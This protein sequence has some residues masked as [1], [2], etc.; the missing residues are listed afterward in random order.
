MAVQAQL[1]LSQSSLN[2]DSGQYLDYGEMSV[3]N[4][5]ADPVELAIG[6]DVRCYDEMDAMALQV[7]I[8]EVCFDFVNIDTLL[9]VVNI[10]PVL[11]LAGGET[12]DLISLHQFFAD[13]YGSEWVLTFFDRENPEDNVELE[14]FVGVCDQANSIEQIAVQTVE[15]GRAYP[16]PANTRVTIPFANRSSESSLVLTDLVGNQVKQVMLEQESG[17]ISLEVSDLPNGVYFYR[18]QTKAQRSAVRSLVVS[19]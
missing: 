9:G 6:V 3:T 2:L 18:I 4:T 19:H 1:T 16:S 12:T 15:L 17:E 5:G 7:C 8:G 11:E 13:D 14:L 10:T